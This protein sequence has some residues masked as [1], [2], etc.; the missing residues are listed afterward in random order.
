MESSWSSCLQP[1][2]IPFLWKKEILRLILAYWQG[3]RRLPLLIRFLRR[4]SGE[5]AE[6]GI[7]GGRDVA[8]IRLVP[9]VRMSPQRRPHRQG[10]GRQG[11]AHR[12]PRFQASRSGRVLIRAFPFSQVECLMVPSKAFA[13]SSTSETFYQQSLK[14]YFRGK[15]SLCQNM[16]RSTNW[17]KLRLIK[18]W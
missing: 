4:D 17:C 11:K 18:M 14:V 8:E 13:Q 15:N 10:L 3:M 12:F 6:T 5:S 1:L 16:W 7:H 9:F 2:T